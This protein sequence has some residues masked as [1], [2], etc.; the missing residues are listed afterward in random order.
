MFVAKGDHLRMTLS[1]KG[2]SAVAPGQYNADGSDLQHPFFAQRSTDGITPER[3][4]ICS[5]SIQLIFS[6]VTDW[7]NA[8]EF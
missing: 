3:G 5:H 8:S 1:E 7:P 6:C 4:L 2:R